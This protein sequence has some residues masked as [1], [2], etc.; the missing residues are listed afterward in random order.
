MTDIVE[1]LMAFADRARSVDRDW[2]PHKP[3]LTQA[4]LIQDAAMEIKHLRIV[5]EQVMEA[6][7]DSD[8]CGAVLMLKTAL[9]RNV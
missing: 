6:I 5:M 4:D 8:E 3:S 2:D 7:G 1:R 9:A